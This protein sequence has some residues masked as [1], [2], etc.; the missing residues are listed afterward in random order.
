MS[1]TTTRRLCATAV[2]LVLVAPAN[3]GI[4]VLDNGSTLSA[5]VATE[6]TARG[7]AV[8]PLSIAETP[9]AAG[10]GAD[11]WVAANLERCPASA[12]R[13]IAA[14]LQKGGG[15]L[16]LGGPPFAT[17]LYPFND[18]WAD[19][20]T[21]LAKAFVPKIA[22]ALKN[23]TP[24]G[25]AVSSDM[26]QSSPTLTLE[27]AV[28]A[29]TGSTASVPVLHGRIT[30]LRSW[31]TFEIHPRQP[32]PRGQLTT[33]WA[34]GTSETNKL[35][36]EWTEQ[37]RSRWI[38]TIDLTPEWQYHVVK[39]EQFMFWYDARSRGRGGPGDRVRIENA[40]KFSVGLALTH[41]PVGPGPHEFWLGDV[42]VA[43]ID[44]QLHDLLS[45]PLLDGLY[46][47]TSLYPTSPVSI[48]VA[49]AYADAL[50]NSTLPVP[51]NC[52]SSYWRPMGSGIDKQRR[53]RFIPVATARNADG[54]RAGTVAAL[55]L[56]LQPPYRNA[57]YGYVSIPD[58][59]VL[60]SQ[61]WMDLTAEMLR[62]MVQRAFLSEA[63]SSQFTYDI[64][65]IPTTGIVLGATA[66]LPSQPPG[67][68]IRLLVDG[69][70]R[71]AAPNRL[72]T[73]LPADATCTGVR[74]LRA[75][76]TSGGRLL[77]VITQELRF[78]GPR[79]NPNYLTAR[80]RVFWR[81]G[82]PWRAFGVN[83]MPSSGLA[84]Q[85]N[86]EFEYWLEDP[87]YDPAIIEHD[88]NRIQA[89]GMN[90]ISVFVYQRS[91]SNGN[92]LDLLSRAR[93]HGLLVNL[94]LRPNEPPFPASKDVVES[95]IGHYRLAEK[96]EIMAYDV[97]W[98]PW[99]G[100]EGIREQRYS[101]DWVKWVNDTHGS[102]GQAARAWKY[103]PGNLATFPDNDKLQKDG[104]WTAAVRDYRRFAHQRIAAE[105]KAGR[106]NI[107]AIDPHHLVSFR[108]SEGANPL[109]DPAQFPIEL[110]AVAQ[111]VDFFSPE[112]YGI[113]DSPAKSS[114]MLFAAS[115]CQALAPGKP[116][117][118][119]E[120][121]YNTWS[122]DAFQPSSRQLEWQ[123]AIYRNVLEH[124]QQSRAAGVIA[125]WFPGGYRK[126]EESDY[127][128]IAP[129]GRSRPA[130]KVLAEYAERL[131][132]PAPAVE[133]TPRMESDAASGARG[134]VALYEALSTRFH[135]AV[136][137]DTI[138]LV[139]RTDAIP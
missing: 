30:N 34:R 45:L 67:Y 54:T 80:D 82:K 138:P 125:W 131:K 77:D 136:T 109:V 29:D 13:A 36:I 90:M 20:K 66:M 103:T 122:G 2:C 121:G 39:P 12:Y 55:T 127:G 139:V 87:A 123:G 51:A 71:A 53:C 21:F 137:S 124:A 101:A 17:M 98:E 64:R 83:Y 115:Y 68:D 11:V 59:A 62:R 79:T 128:L 28:I 114:T 37:D 60:L 76:L 74:H 102:P 49:E 52:W 126:G 24:A 72:R 57:L 50:N 104:Q 91:I 15:F 16:A 56:Y 63:G 58:P 100:S 93:A 133:W 44:A 10:A 5:S 92:L 18:G 1:T 85:H 78:D 129:D 81:G 135:S 40:R 33:F 4:R 14:H 84:L 97:A 75:E 132:A 88:L 22:L 110:A 41:T 70:A 134:Y 95:L 19:E 113:G 117:L 25:I 86:L 120:F 119:S 38:A 73:T 47:R 112:A 118:W 42:G 6:L 130:T 8:S 108:Q 32:M 3:A 111:A 7:L 106:Q 31:S 65:D 61:S 69:V 107:R 116:V 96:D 9:H 35:A 26:P 94:S 89:L 27:S 99:W 23:V 105:Y 43:Q 46:P 48:D